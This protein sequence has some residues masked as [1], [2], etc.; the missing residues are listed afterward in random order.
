M[1]WGS[2]TKQVISSPREILMYNILI[3][4]K[5]H[6]TGSYRQI[7]FIYGLNI[8]VKGERKMKRLFTFFKRWYYDLPLNLKLNL[9]NIFIIVLPMV[10]LAFFINKVSSEIIIN[11]SIRSSVQSL[12]VVTRSIDSL[13]N[14][15]D[16]LSKL[17]ATNNSVQQILQVPE[18]NT[19]LL[20]KRIDVISSLDSIVGDRDIISSA[21]IF[22]NN[23]LIFNSSSL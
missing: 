12:N 1:G 20:E 7:G 9:T 6:R 13:L 16:Y 21:I 15:T 3:L 4:I 8:L 19:T 18:Y 11:Q 22:A 23:G 17:I 14:Q 5:S 10:L 2:S